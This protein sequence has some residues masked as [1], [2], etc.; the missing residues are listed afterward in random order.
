MN[1]PDHD[2][3]AEIER[4]RQRDRGPFSR[5][6]VAIET[7]LE[8]LVLLLFGC[9]VVYLGWLFAKSLH[10]PIGDKPIGSLTLN[11]I[12]RIPTRW[13]RDTRQLGHR[14]QGRLLQGHRPGPGATRSG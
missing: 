8:R 13:P 2:V 3:Q 11:D 1:A 6:F 9:G 10:H 4:L 14:S 5:A 12:G 7:T